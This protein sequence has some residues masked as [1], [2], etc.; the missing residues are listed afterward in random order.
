MA[1]VDFRK[2]HMHRGTVELM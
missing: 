1:A 2:D